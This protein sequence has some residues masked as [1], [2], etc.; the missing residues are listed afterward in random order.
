[1]AISLDEPAA[2]RAFASSYGITFPLLT[3]PEG[4]TSRAYVGID[5]TDTPIPG[6][7]VVRRD[8]Q[9]VFRQ[10]A[11]AKDD[12]LTAAQLLATL[13]RTLGTGD[14]AP[15]ARTGYAVLDR[16][17]L[18]FALGG[19]RAE[20]ETGGDRSIAVG[21]ASALVPLGRR[22]L[23]GPAIR[24]EPLD[25]PL[26]LDLA[27]VMRFPILADAAALELTALGG[28]TPWGATDWNAGVRGGAWVALNPWW[29]MQLEA[30][31][32]AHRLGG[33]STIGWTI[34]LGVSRLIEL[35]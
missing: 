19:G 22:F 24:V 30:G 10:I 23:I 7:V 15:A 31:A 3:D 28:Y 35:R 17:Q 8:G 21:S 4:T 14:G 11:A 29:A 18:R 1:M 32:S 20:A 9:I 34:T 6:I 33:D 13:D 26:D 5:A 16:L 12:R 2:S 27:V 25:A